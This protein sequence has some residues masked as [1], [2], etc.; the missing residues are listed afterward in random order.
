MKARQLL[1]LV[2]P[3]ALVWMTPIIGVADQ[4]QDEAAIRKSIANYVAAFNRGDAK[5]IAAMWSPAAVYTNRY[6][7][8]QVSGRE[9]IEKEL[10]SIFES[11]KGIKV[12][13]DVTSV[14]FMSPSVAVEEG[15]ARVIRPGEEPDET[16]YSSV[17]IRSG[18]GWLL[19]H[20]SEEPK[21][22]Y[23]SNYQHLKDLEWMIGTWVDQD[24][25]ARIETVSS[26]T[27]NQNFITRKF[28]VSVE[29]DT[30]L[31]GIQMIGWDPIEQEIRSWVFDSD[32]G[33]G[34]ATWTKKGN[35]W[36][37]NAAATLADGRKASVVTTLTMM[38]DQTIMWEATG[39]TIDGNILPNI[40]PIKLTRNAESE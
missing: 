7:G 36:I 24:D 33:F 4:A 15:V 32:G 40:D 34:S 30:D 39:R 6:T 16:V 26:W 20:M 35:K 2:V 9:N 10:I 8:E 17:Y 31:A 25:N 5:A 11:S 3:L 22:V 27:K 29:G 38:D 28:A 13:V 1:S 23:R 37:V 12:E 21:P 19:D 14:K 18:D